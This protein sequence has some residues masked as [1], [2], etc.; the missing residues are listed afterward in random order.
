MFQELFCGP[1]VFGQPADHFTG[2]IDE[3]FPFLASQ[4]GDGRLPGKVL[5]HVIGIFEFAVGVEEEKGFFAALNEFLGRRPQETNH[6][7]E[8][9][10]GTVVVWS[11][12]DGVKQTKGLKEVPQHDAEIP[13]VGRVGPAAIENDLWGHEGVGLNGLVVVLIAPL[14]QA[15]VGDL[16]GGDDGLSGS[17]AKVGTRLINDAAVMVG[18]LARGGMFE[19]VLDKTIKDGGVTQAHH[20]I[21]G[22]EVG[23]NNL[24]IGVEIVETLE[25]GGEQDADLFTAEATVGKLFHAH[26]NGLSQDIVDDA[27]VFAVLGFQLEGVEHEANVAIAG[28]GGVGGEQLFGDCLSAFQIV[29]GQDVD[30][31]LDGDKLVIAGVFGP[32][33]GRV[34]R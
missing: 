19:L 13:N 1:S 15:N 28:V 3:Q 17:L 5:K 30:V 14:G 20:D 22:F 27:Q 2:K 10:F 34:S 8:V 12:V 16:G 7:T 21:V 18:C 29:L 6:E 23:V 33:Q 32:V 25:E 4:A 11:G 31:D 9:L 26:V 24:A